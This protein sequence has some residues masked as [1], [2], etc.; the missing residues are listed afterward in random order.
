[1]TNDS[2]TFKVSASDRQQTSEKTLTFTRNRTSLSVTLEEP[3]AADDN[4]V[5]CQ[6]NVEGNIPD[7]AVCTYEVTNNA[8]DDDPVWEDCTEQIKAGRPHIFI[9]KAANGFAFNFRV[10]IERGSSNTGGYVTKIWG[11]FE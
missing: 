11:G 5:A 8:L 10:S 7:D 3:L 6:L 4:I 9:N 2:H 1:M